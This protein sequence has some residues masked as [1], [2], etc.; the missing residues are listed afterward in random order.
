VAVVDQLAYPPPILRLA[1]W[2]DPR[3]AYF[4]HK[5]E[6]FGIATADH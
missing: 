3:S 5:P 6:L 1:F 4:A 2:R